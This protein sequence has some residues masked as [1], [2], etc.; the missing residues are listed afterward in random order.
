[1]PTTYSSTQYLDCPR[2]MFNGPGDRRRFIAQPRERSPKRHS[3]RRRSRGSRERGE[4]E[5]LP[6]YGYPYMEAGDKMGNGSNG[7]FKR[8]F[9]GNPDIDPYHPGMMEFRG[10]PR[11]DIMPLVM[12]A[13][14]RVREGIVFEYGNY[15]EFLV[16]LL[17]ESNKVLMRVNPLG[18]PR[19]IEERISPT[20]RAEKS[21]IIVP[22][23][24]FDRNDLLHC[25]IV[26]TGLPPSVFF[27]SGFGH[28][29]VLARDA[30]AKDLVDKF[31]RVGLVTEALHASIGS[32]PVFRKGNLP[33]KDYAI[34]LDALIDLDKKMSECSWPWDI[35]SARELEQDVLD[36]L[37]FVF[38]AVI[39]DIYFR[40]NQHG[41]DRFRADPM[42][43]NGSMNSGII[44]YPKKMEFCRRCKLSGHSEGECGDEYAEKRLKE[45]ARSRSPSRSF[46]TEPHYDRF[47][48]GEWYHDHR[49][50]G[51]V[52]TQY[53][54][55]EIAQ[56]IAE[57]RGELLR[58]EMMMRPIEAQSAP[59][60]LLSKTAFLPQPLLPPGKDIATFDQ[61]YNPSANPPFLEH[62]FRPTRGGEE[63]STGRG[64]DPRRIDEEQFLREKERELER[65]MQKE[66]E[67]RR[68]V[69]EEEI[70]KQ[71]QVEE[72]AKLQMELSQ[73]LPHRAPQISDNSFP[74][75][76]PKYPSSSAFLLPPSL[77]TFVGNKYDI[78]PNPE[79]YSSAPDFEIEEIKRL[80]K[81]TEEKLLDLQRNAREAELAA[82]FESRAFRTVAELGENAYLLD[83]SQ[84]QLLLS[85]LKEILSHPGPP[86]RNTGHLRRSRSREK[87]RRKR[88]SHH[89]DRGYSHRSRSSRRHGSYRSSGDRETFKEVRHQIGGVTVRNLDSSEQ[90]RLKVGDIVAAQDE[91][92]GKWATAHIAKI[93]GDTATLATGN[94][95]W[96]KALHELFKEVPEWSV[97]Y[98]IHEYIM[99]VAE[100]ENIEEGLH[101]SIQA[102][103]IKDVTVQDAEENYASIRADDAIVLGNP[104]ESLQ[105]LDQAERIK[106]GCEITKEHEQNAMRID[107]N[108]LNSGYFSPLI[109]L[110]ID[111]VLSRHVASSSSVVP[112]GHMRVSFLDPHIQSGPQCGLAALSMSSQ[113][114]GLERKKISDMLEKAKKLGFTVQGEMFSADWLGEL[115]CA[116]WPL[117]AEILSFPS[118]DELIKL[119]AADYAV[120]VPYDCDR[121]HEPALRNGHG[122]HWAILVGFLNVD[123]NVIG[124]HSAPPD[125]HVLEDESFYVFAYHGKS[126]HMAL[127]SYCCLRRSCCQLYE[128][129]PMRKAP[130]YMIPEDGLSQLRGKCVCLKKLEG[131][132]SEK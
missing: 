54:P 24:D 43:T 78:E 120:F 4:R 48:Q 17:D 21:R 30:A 33:E 52:G 60:S 19:R 105:E 61:P 45:R 75:F 83:R 111:E 98:R 72:R 10:P 85:E 92:T 58:R 114:L 56:K 13:N 91:K 59:H 7:E 109:R 27:G 6:P 38:N 110:R 80:V 34:A 106:E 116:L 49:D 73:R 112:G 29:P 18:Q 76:S 125:L 113:L 126:K 95:T 40:G 42:D 99:S 96:K 1:M 71:V 122:A 8:M 90:R 74:S 132:I 79:S 81:E 121:N 25:D 62:E 63:F 87:S 115:A 11:R 20:T 130:D 64:A 124:L 128:P 46:R 86:E 69:L 100:V 22:S 102:E 41:R 53:T 67:D 101:S 118:P 3:K 77:S 47:R 57:Q 23:Y 93:S 66:F 89:H 12:P 94:T 107:N 55:D 117:D 68:R 16:D 37:K 15:Y 70:R 129:G 31:Y 103:G 82:I 50:I 44:E 123:I 32:S 9:T 39:D 35:F 26:I 131:S 5:P 36:R 119:M 84:K 108:I 14:E 97:V 104:P 65:R 2:T 51:N 88:T 28:R 127:W